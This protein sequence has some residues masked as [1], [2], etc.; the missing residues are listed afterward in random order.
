MNPARHTSVTCRAR[1]A[2]ASAR[3]KSSREANCLMIEDEGLDARRARPLQ[4]GRAR[5]VRDD[6]GDLRIEAAT[7]DRVDER[8][9]I[10][11]APRDEDADPPPGVRPHPATFRCNPGS[12]PGPT[13]LDAIRGRQADCLPRSHH[14]KTSSLHPWGFRVSRVQSRIEKGRLCSTSPEDYTA[15]DR[16]ASNEARDET[17]MR[18]IAYCLM[19]EPLAS[20]AMARARWRRSPDSCSG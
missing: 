20:S 3:S 4:A 15:F 16:A 8:L 10:A 2:S 14:G 7:G 17:T 9:E 11:A 1:S 19:R 12:D 5:L 13:D 6:D 18:I